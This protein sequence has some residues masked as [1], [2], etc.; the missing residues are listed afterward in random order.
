TLFLSTHTFELVFRPQPL[1]VRRN[2]PRAILPAFA[3]HK[4]EDFGFGQN[5]GETLPNFRQKSKGIETRRVTRS[6][7]PDIRQVSDTHKTWLEYQSGIGIG[8]VPDSPFERMMNLPTTRKLALKNKVVFGTSD[9][10]CAP[11]VTANMA[12]VRAI[13]QNGM[14]FFT[15]EHRP[16]ALTEVKHAP[17]DGDIKSLR[18]LKI[19]LNLEGGVFVKRDLLDQ[20]RLEL[21]RT[22]GGL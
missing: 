9:Y 1:E 21:I 13:S 4:V 14:S 3:P 11:T 8:V 6:I 16:R 7:V 2:P 10:W 19:C 15:I 5:T 18:D 12:F 22:P 17:M 20:L